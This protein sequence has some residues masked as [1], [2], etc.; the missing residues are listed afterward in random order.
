[1][2]AEL[3][4]RLITGVPPVTVRIA[5][6]VAVPQ[7]PVVVTVTVWLPTLSEP[8]GTVML[9]LLPLNGEPSRVHAYE[10]GPVPDAVVEK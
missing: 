5:V 9:G 4:L 1:M 6:C 8:V 10:N 3:E 7:D 2:V